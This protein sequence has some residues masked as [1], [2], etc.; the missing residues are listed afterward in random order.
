MGS[1]RRAASTNGLIVTVKQND[2]QTYERRRDQT[3]EEIALVRIELEDARIEEI[4]VE[5]PS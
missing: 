3:R 5:V 2:G 1:F 4:D